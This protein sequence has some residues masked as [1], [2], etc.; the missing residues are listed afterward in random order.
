MVQQRLQVR[1]APARSRW[2]R[3]WMPAAYE[4]VE[5]ALAAVV[6]VLLV[7][8]CL[9][10]TA[11]V[12][13]V[14]MRP[15]LQDG[16]RVVILQLGC[17]D[18]DYGELVVVD[19]SPAGQPPIIKRVV[20]RAGDII[21][22]DFAAGVVWRNGAPLEEPYVREPTHTRWDMA[23]PLQVP[24]G[25]LFVLGDNRNH[26]VDSRSSKIGLV[27]IRRVMGRAVFRLHP[28]QTAGS[29]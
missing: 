5:A 10:R 15:T 11:T 4:W 1:K 12:S 28:F 14:S 9:L 13:G 23:F 17:Q 29:I 3:R 24:A 20:G 8:T 6:A 22:I 27:D 19:G 2:A 25:C 21:D 18:P 16:D 7:F 26:S